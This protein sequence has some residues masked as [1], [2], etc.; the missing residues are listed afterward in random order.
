[1][2]TPS[3]DLLQAITQQLSRIPTAQG[4]LAVAA[5]QLGAQ[6]EGLARLDDLD[7]ATVEPAT[8]LLSPPEVYHGT[9]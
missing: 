7:L 2:G 3:T 8:V 6:M 5:A 9:R 4:D 1:M